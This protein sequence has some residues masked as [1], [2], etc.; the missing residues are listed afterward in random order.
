MIYY[1]LRF[2]SMILQIINNPIVPI[3][4]DNPINLHKLRSFIWDFIDLIHRSNKY[5]KGFP[6]Y[7][8]DNNSLSNHELLWI[9]NPQ[10]SPLPFHIRIDLRDDNHDIDIGYYDNN[11][12]EDWMIIDWADT[13]IFRYIY[14]RSFDMNRLG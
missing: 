10:F 9:S 6:I 13:G 7:I 4:P 1:K 3:I 2:P 14:E 8:H 12:I 5:Y 11:I